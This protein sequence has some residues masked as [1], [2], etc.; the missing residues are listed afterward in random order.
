MRTLRIQPHTWQKITL[1][2]G[3][4]NLENITILSFKNNLEEKM[5]IV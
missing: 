3:Y 1:I 2:E 5:S 4:I